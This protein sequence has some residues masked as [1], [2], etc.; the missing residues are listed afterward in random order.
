MTRTIHILREAEQKLLRGDDVASVAHPEEPEKLPY[1]IQSSP[2]P[3]P[4]VES[5]SEP[6]AGTPSRE[7]IP[8]HSEASEE[9]PAPGESSPRFGAEEEV[10]ILGEEE[11]AGPEHFPEPADEPDRGEFP[12]EGREEVGAHASGPTLAPEELI[13]EEDAYTLV[14][15]RSKMP[16]TAFRPGS[17]SPSQVDD[18]LEE[19]QI[20]LLQPE[21]SLPDR[22]SA[23]PERRSG[24]PPGKTAL[25]FQQPFDSVE[26]MELPGRPSSRKGMVRPSEEIRLSPEAAGSEKPGEHLLPATLRHLLKFIREGG[27]VRCIDPWNQNCAAFLL[28]SRGAPVLA[29]DVFMNYVRKSLPTLRTLFEKILTEN[30]P[31]SQ[32]SPAFRELELRK[33]FLSHLAGA[34]ATQRTAGLHSVDGLRISRGSALGEEF[35]FE[36]STID[37]IHPGLLNALRDLLRNPVDQFFQSD[38]GFSEIADFLAKYRDFTHNMGEEKQ[39]GAMLRQIGQE[40]GADPAGSSGNSPDLSPQ[41]G[42]TPRSE[43]TNPGVNESSFYTEEESVRDLDTFDFGP[44]DKS[45]IMR[46]DEKAMSQSAF[47]QRE[48]G[49]RPPEEHGHAS[50]GASPTTKEGPSPSR[51]KLRASSEL[52]PEDDN[53]FD[54]AELENLLENGETGSGP[55]KK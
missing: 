46:I 11:E 39:A 9:F 7:E 50:G 53:A 52:L 17:A 55:G 42:Q 8:S 21:E 18:F 29:T 40:I 25:P 54:L 19:G 1:R 34:L 4:K 38:G 30:P 3:G 27:A 37:Y 43:G 47:Q 16:E 41:T 44:D 22:E 6:A 10:L 28:P 15:E 45:S 2:V 31:L 20:H 5:P 35:E 33:R 13:L 14:P 32:D 51:E 24:T 12:N 26:D 36:R 48:S 49:Q 23:S